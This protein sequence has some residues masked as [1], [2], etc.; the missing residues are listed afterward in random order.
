[1]DISIS[2]TVEK[3]IY[4]SPSTWYSVCDVSLDSGE[5]ITIVG[6]MPY[7]AVGEGIEASGNWITSKDYGKQF[8]VEEYKKSLPQ[9]KNSILRYLS[10]GAIKGIG[11]KIA[12]KIVDEY[13]E[14]AFDVIENHPDWLARLPGITPKRAMEIS[15]EFKSKSDIRATVTFFREYFGPATTMKIYKCFGKHSVST[16]PLK[17]RF[18]INA[19]LCI[20]RKLH[21]PV[22]RRAPLRRGKF[23]LAHKR[24]SG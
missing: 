5:V 8:K 9:K 19:R 11:A 20:I 12:K 18:N 22:G 2:G 21:E 3:I 7:I 6:T 4:Q 13:G 17:L 15:E 14:D 23:I 1:M 10:S 24:R 16:K